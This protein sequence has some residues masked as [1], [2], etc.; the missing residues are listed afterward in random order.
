M[1]V[2]DFPLRRDKLQALLVSWGRGGRFGRE[3]Q[4]GEP[5]KGAREPGSQ[6]ARRKPR[7]AASELHKQER[8]NKRMGNNVVEVNCMLHSGVK[9][10]GSPDG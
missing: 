2:R 3:S 5:G 4:G 8:T 6:G 9:Q 7:A 10:V 1:G